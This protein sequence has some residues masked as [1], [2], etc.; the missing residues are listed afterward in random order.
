[1]TIDWNDMRLSCLDFYQEVLHSSDEALGK[2]GYEEVSIFYA[3]IWIQLQI[4]TNGIALGSVVVLQNGRN[5]GHATG[6]EIQEFELHHVLKMCETHLFSDAL[7]CS[8]AMDDYIQENRLIRSEHLLMFDWSSLV[9]MTSVIKSPYVPAHLTHSSSDFLNVM[10]PDSFADN[11]DVALQPLEVVPLG[12]IRDMLRREFNI[13]AD[14]TARFILSHLNNLGFFDRLDHTALL[15]EDGTGNDVHCIFPLPF[16]LD[17]SA[18]VE[19]LLSAVEGCLSDLDLSVTEV[20]LLLLVRRFWPNCLTTELVF[21][22]L[23]R[24]LLRWILSEV[25][26]TFRTDDQL[27]STCM[28]G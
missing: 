18:N 1:M 28:T 11:P 10:Q 15:F 21:R 25:R 20:G 4:L 5:A 19:V 22:R 17:L 6:Y 24:S 26:Y 8:G 23:T 7:R 3:S 2:L 27:D 9:Y 13:H 16:G 12:H 14:F